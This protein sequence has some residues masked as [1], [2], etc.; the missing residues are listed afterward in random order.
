MLSI[1]SDVAEFH[2][3]LKVENGPQRAVRDLREGLIIEE[4]T[5]VLCA[6]NALDYDT[7][8]GQKRL[9]K[10]L[11]DLLY[12]VAGTADVFGIDL[13][14]YWREVHAS[15]LRKLGGSRSATGKILKPESWVG[16]DLDAAYGDQFRIKGP[17]SNDEHRRGQYW[18]RP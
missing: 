14:P 3:K 6:L 15:N 9:A 8:G 1:Q 2:R 17:V 16:P 7:P 5:E 12:V 4:G 18:P 11:C 10:E 13:E